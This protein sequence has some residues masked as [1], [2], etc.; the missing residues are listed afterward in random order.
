MKKFAAG[1]TLIELLVVISIIG[2]LSAIGMTAFTNAQK[3]ARDATR[4][5]DMKAYQSTYEQYYAT[6]GAGSYHDSCS[7]MDAGFSGAAPTDP[8]PGWTAYSS[9]C[10]ATTYYV[11]AE[12][13]QQAGNAS[14]GDGS[15]G[16]GSFY[17]VANLQ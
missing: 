2:I 10:T 6:D 13:E 17:C 8:K 12:L 3:K 1:F 9:D 4:I 16:T 15:F 11:C 7:T 5:G 14:A